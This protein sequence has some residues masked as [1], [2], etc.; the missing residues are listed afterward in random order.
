MFQLGLFGSGEVLVDESAPIEQIDLPG[1]AW[2]QVSRGWLR[3]AD[4][5]CQELQGSVPWRQH[6]RWMYERLVDE[7]RLS[8]WYYRAREVPGRPLDAVEEA[9]SRRFRVP[10][11]GP[12]LNYYRDGRD[13]VAFHSD[14][15]LRHLEDTI[16]AIVTLGCSRPFLVRPKAGGPSVDL[17]PGTGDLLVMGGTC[18][19]LYDHG[20]PKVA[21]AG[22]RIS[23]SWRWAS[24]PEPSAAERPAAG[25]T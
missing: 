2:A 4:E 5:L 16:V 7:P 18:Q 21:S 12:G 14:R 6:K 9:L 17:R 10:L 11:K 20:V 1:G 23:A 15:E 19:L 3:G 13:S 24:G 8:C 22:P 25:T